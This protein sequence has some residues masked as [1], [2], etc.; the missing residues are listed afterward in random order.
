VVIDANFVKLDLFLEDLIFF[1][2]YF[3]KAFFLKNYLIKEIINIQ[4]DLS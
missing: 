1:F 3:L 4:L 2:F